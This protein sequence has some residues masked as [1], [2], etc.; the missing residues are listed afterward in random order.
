[1]AEAGPIL[2]RHAR[3][4]ATIGLVAGSLMLAPVALAASSVPLPRARPATTGA[5]AAQPLGLRPDIVATARPA[6]TSTKPDAPM[7]LALTAATP[8]ADKALT[9]QAIEL[10]KAGKWGQ[11]DQIAQAIGD[12]V[13]R[14]LIEWVLLRHDDSAADFSRYFAFINANPSWPSVVFLRRRAEASLWQEKSPSSTIRSFFARARPMSAKG[15]F[16]LARA[17]LADGDRAGAAALVREAWRQDGFGR[18]VEQM[19]FDQFGD[20]LT[21]ADHK[22]RMDMRLYSDDSEGALRAA[23]R[24]GGNAMAIAKARN[25]VNAK[26]GNAKALLDAVPAEG[27][28]DAGYIFSLVQYLRRQD[29]I[30]EAATLLLSAPRELAE[31]R[32]PD[33]WWV[34]RRTIARKLLDDGD[35]QTAYRLVREATPPERDNWRIEQQFL[36]GF[37]ALRYLEQPALAQPHFARIAKMEED[38]PHAASRAGYWLG[39]TAEALGKQ[40]DARGHY[41]SAAQFATTYY[42]QLARA[43]LGMKDLVLRAPPQ[44]HPNAARLELVRALE[45]LYAIDEPGYV[46]SIVADVAERTNDASALAALAEVALRNG[47]ARAALLTGKAALNRGMPLE[48]YAFPTIGIPD[49]R[50]LGPAVEASLVYA[51]ARQESMFSQSVVSPANAYG[52][53]QVTPPAGRY[54]AKRWG[55]TFDQKKLQN[56]PVYNVQMGAAEL[57]GLLEDFNGSYIM[58]FVGY[59]A[60]RTRVKQWIEAYGDPRDGKVDPVDWVERIPFAETRN[61]VM[62]IMENLQVY[63]MRFGGSGRLT[64]EADLRRGGPGN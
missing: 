62:R 14:K 10:V 27:K 30:K 2:R 47:D 39:R 43:R 59:N 64:I 23:N 25:A 58:T 15:R 44:K 32:D 1:M 34:E 4:T 29:K 20:M 13:A 55:G 6:A 18:D 17:L 63:R 54:I 42:G 51:I 53:M 40:H 3:R 60:G 26:A 28:R 41:D 9:K 31:I 57:S 8:A 45:L 49:Y 21:P 38:N 36:S 52:L 33:D 37:I 50:A 22:A 11:A 24:L 7:A 16:A 56:D 61:Y 48:H 5:A 12:P 35:A 19:A 46:T